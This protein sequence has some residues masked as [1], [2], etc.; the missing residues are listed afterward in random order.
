MRVPA[1]VL[2]PTLREKDQGHW[3]ANRPWEFCFGEISKEIW[4]HRSPKT[5]LA[6]LE[7]QIPLGPGSLQCPQR[8]HMLTDTRTHMNT[9]TLSLTYTLRSPPHPVTRLLRLG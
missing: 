7:K 4:S 8:A 5:G 3:D 2:T 9:L 1:Q 6:E